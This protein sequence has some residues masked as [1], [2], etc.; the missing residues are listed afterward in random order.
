MY[1]SEKMFIHRSNHTPKL[2]VVRVPTHKYI[3]TNMSVE[4]WIYYKNRKWI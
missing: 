4:R 2:N 3:V 1:L